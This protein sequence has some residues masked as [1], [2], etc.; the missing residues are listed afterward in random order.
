MRSLFRHSTSYVTASSCC[1]SSPPIA[2]FGEARSLPPVLAV[3]V[4]GQV[5]SNAPGPCHVTTDLAQVY[6]ILPQVRLIAFVLCIVLGAWFFVLLTLFCSG[7][8]GQ[9]SFA[10]MQFFVNRNASGRAD[11]RIG[12]DNNSKLQCFLCLE[13]DDSCAVIIEFIW[14]VALE[15]S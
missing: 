5:H 1:V 3:V 2:R 13:P 11:R 4:M 15:Y 8:I 10:W 12:T 7:L 9:A 6:L 14:S